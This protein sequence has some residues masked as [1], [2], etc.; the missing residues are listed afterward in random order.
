MSLKAFKIGIWTE[1]NFSKSINGK[2]KE[3]DLAQCKKKRRNRKRARKKE[4][5]VEFFPEENRRMNTYEIQSLT[6][7]H[8]QYAYKFINA[9]A[10]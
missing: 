7:T 10:D 8:T 9:F 6:F 2:K 1:I 4:T 3:E 5:R